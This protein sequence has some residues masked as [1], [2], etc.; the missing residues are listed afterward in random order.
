MIDKEIIKKIKR[1]EI[2]SDKIANEVFSGEYHSFFKGNGMEFEDIREYYSGDDIRNIDW[3]VTARQGRAYVKKFKEERELNL[4]LLIDVSN[5]NYFGKKQDIIAELGAA[6][7]FSAVKNND[8]IGSIFFT[9]KIEKFIPSKKGKRHV[10]SII[11]NIL[12][13]KPES[14]GTNIKEALKYFNQ[15]EKKRSIVFLIS[16]FLDKDYDNEI[17][18]ISLKHDLILLRVIERKEEK[19][20]KGAI[21]SFEDLET[22]EEIVIDNSKKEIKLDLKRKLPSKNML[23]IYTDEDFIKP[24]MLFFKKR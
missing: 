7:A 22:G 12:S 2:K 10:L 8:K 9:D 4:F 3:N 13:F 21:F 14:K 11:E 23:N 20:P 16:D 24:L 5:S 17:K 18:T 19:I 15:I 6:I 1:I